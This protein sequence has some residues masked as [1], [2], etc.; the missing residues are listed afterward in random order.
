MGIGWE[1]FLGL[2]SGKHEVP[3]IHSVVSLTD[4]VWGMEASTWDPGGR[5]YTVPAAQKAGSFS[6]Q[7]YDD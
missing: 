3:A 5:N 4:C 2:G 1:T 7:F 6:F